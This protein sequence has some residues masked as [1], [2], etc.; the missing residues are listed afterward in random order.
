MS[1]ISRKYVKLTPIEHI[2]KRPGMYI[3]GVEQIDRLVW[4]LDSSGEKMIR[5]NI[6]YSPGLFK[7]FDELMVNVYDQTTRDPT[8]R[9]IRV[10]IDTVTNEITVFNDGI[11]L[12]VVIHPEEQI[13]VPELIFGHL[14]TSTSFDD[15]TV[16][17][18]G[19]IHGLGA[20][21]TAIFSTQFKID[22]GDPVNRKRFRQV[23]RRN[24]S[25]RSK[26]IVDDYKPTKG[27]VRIAYKPDM[28]Y[29][30]IDRFD[31]DMIALMRRRVFDIAAITRDG[32]RVFID[33][34][35]VFV[36]T[37]ENYVAMYTDGEQFPIS[38]E[39]DS[40]RYEEGRWKLIITQ[41]R[42]EFEQ[43]SFVNG[44]NTMDGGYHVNY[45]VD[46]IVRRIREYV[47]MRYKTD[48]IKDRFI[49]NQLSIC[50]SAV[51]ENPTFSSQ[52]KN[53]LMT[54]VDKFGSTC[55][56]SERALKKFYTSEPFAR[57]IGQQI[58]LVEKQE[59]G[60]TT[61]RRKSNIVSIPKLYDANYAGTSR[62]SE[63]K[64]ILTEGDS[65]KTMAVSG[66]GAIPRSS[67]I[68]GV[69]PLKGKL[70]NVRDQSHQ[71]IIQ[72]TEFIN[73]KNIMGLKI[74]RQ[75]TLD[76]IGELRYG[77]IIL[78]MD[79]D[80]D[81]S[82]I[83]GLLINMMHYYWPSLLEIDGFIKIFI[84]PIVKVSHKNEINIFYNNDDYVKGK[85]KNDSNV[86]KIKYYKG[87][88]TNTA[89]EAKEYFKNLDRHQIDM[90]WDDRSNGA[91]ELGFSKASAEDRKKWLMRYDPSDQNDHLK[92]TLTYYNFIHRELIHFSNYDNVRSIPNIIDG[93]KPSQRKVL[94]AAF[95]KDLR[96]EIKVAQFVGYIGEHTAYHHGEVSLSNTI[97]AMAQNFVGSNNINLFDPI[98]QF[99]TRLLGGRDHSS[100]R[101]IFTRLNRITRYIFRKEDD[102]LLEYLD[103]DG[104]S[105]E[106]KFYV[107]IIPMI[108]VN[109]S[110]GIGTGYST[111][112]PKFNPLDIIRMIRNKIRG[113]KVSH[114][115]KPWYR[116]FIGEINNVSKNVYI[117]T[118]VFERD[119]NKVILKELPI[120]TWTDR[121]REHLTKLTTENEHIREI[122]HNSTDQTVDISIRF[123]NA[124]TIYDMMADPTNIERLFGLTTTI[125]QTNMHGYDE[126]MRIRKYK[127]IRE[128]VDN[129]FN[130]RLYYYEVRK[131]YIV[132]KLKHQLLIIESKVRFIQSIIDGTIVV[133]NRPYDQIIRT[134]HQLLFY[135]LTDDEPFDY[136][137]NISI[138]QMTAENISELTKRLKEKQNTYKELQKKSINQ[139]WLDE[140][141]ALE[142]VIVGSDS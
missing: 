109:G 41:S 110:E 70:I 55:V 133:M 4:I 44:I 129:F 97:I 59:F 131:K 8:L 25:E 120:G 29:F 49:R 137:I 84:T 32:V 82:H 140:L 112:I 132:D 80:V 12:D 42:G 19:G 24:L 94:Y 2:L 57:M 28:K 106:P 11:G 76:N 78:M 102:D 45:V 126:K 43:I 13:Y 63:C 100:P 90:I 21:L 67:N 58:D 66:L 6:H 88:G 116:G 15:E 68:Y 107:P 105:I 23:Y 54:P 9:N 48:R 20:K 37:L 16:R 119:R 69:F 103:D 27:Y 74:D 33:G 71:R 108:L 36:K 77:S 40:L 111:F 93:L 3:G 87:L 10:D 96:N 141:D 142:G 60:K 34:E 75:Y 62:S 46:Q 51:I 134:L 118:G 83:K 52:T 31:E 61:I 14:L 135:K 113:T 139:M 124:Q 53:E 122:R 98:G 114:S 123:D 125:N 65:A 79:A 104:I 30:K 138:R 130:V 91:I 86:W 56:V 101:Y 47:R 99:G 89:E 127:N 39:K 7:I 26:P 136:L 121:Y 64:L 81:G 1:K 115:I 128:I 85:N 35:R 5:R 95:K 38:C 73:L 22:I 72:N 18:T 17:T 92:H 117:S 50:L